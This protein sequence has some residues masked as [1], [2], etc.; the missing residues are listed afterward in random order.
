MTNMPTLGLLLI[1]AFAACSGAGMAD[2]SHIQL[3]PPT[4]EGGQSLVEVIKDRR[5]RREFTTEPLTL[6]DVS[7]LLWAAQ[8]ITSQ[9]GLRSAPSAG[10]LY[11]LVLYL[12]AGAVEGLAPGSYRY[13]PF[14]QSLE[15]I[16]NGE[17]RSGLAHAA[18]HQMWI[19][20]AAAAVVIT[21]IYPRTT[22]K[23]AERGIRY[24]HMEAGHA[25]QN[26]LLQAQAMGLGSVVVGAF[27]DDTLKTLLHLREDEQPLSILPI[28]HP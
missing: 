7:Q 15:N 25:G 16:V 18:L 27:N 9:D 2:T 12:I 10:A 4:L 17:L 21:A 22:R 14:Q 3:P 5:S 1:L 20:Q 19:E 6:Q 11:P 8:G 26:L 13:D 23:Y 24:V 28:G